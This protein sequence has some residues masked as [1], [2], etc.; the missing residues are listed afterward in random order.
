MRPRASAGW[1]MQPA[2]PLLLAPPPQH[3]PHAARPHIP[4][5]A[6]P[7]HQRA[8]GARCARARRHAHASSA[9][10]PFANP[11]RS[12]ARAI[13][14]CSRRGLGSG[15]TALTGCSSCDNST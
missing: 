2:A 15:S 4:R 7:L 11:V 3:A 6:V 12:S 5:R 9:A 8:P 14:T 1:R 10:L 13:A